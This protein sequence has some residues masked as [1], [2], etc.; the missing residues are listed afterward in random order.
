MLTEKIRSDFILLLA[1]MMENK[2]RIVATDLRSYKLDELKKRAKRAGAFNI[3]PADLNRMNELAAT[4]KGFDKI[5]V[6]APCSGTGT[7]ARNPDAKWRMDESWFQN[8]PVEQAGIIEKA[9]PYLKKNG[10]LYYATCSLEP[11]ENECVVEKIL[12]THPELKCMP[13]D[14][15]GEKFFRLWPPE[16]RTDGFFLA[17]MEKMQ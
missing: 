10:K 14:A 7:L 1:A 11:A 16:S 13:C 5:L 8:L 9:L 12:E 15:S 2:G 6:D 4:K 17:I 3:F